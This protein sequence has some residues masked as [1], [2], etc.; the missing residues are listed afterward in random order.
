MGIRYY[1]WVFAQSYKISVAQTIAIT[2]AS[3]YI[4]RHLVN[5]LRDISGIQVRILCR[6]RQRGVDTFGL[7]SNLEIVEGNLYSPESLLNLLKPG[8]TVINLAYLW[9]NGET[10]NL[11]AISNLTSA[12]IDRNVKRL[13]HCSTAAVAGRSPDNLI[14]ENTPCQPIT[15][16]GI[17]KLKIERAIR[18]AAHGN[19]EISILRPTSVFGLDGEPLKKL[20]ADLVAGNR[21]LNYLKSCLFGYRRMNL[22]HVTNVVAAISFLTSYQENVDGEVFIISD[23]DAIANNF[24]EVERTLMRFLDCPDYALPP[25]PLPQWALSLLLR[26][27]GRNNINP[28]CNYSQSKLQNLGFKRSVIFEDGLMEYAS[29]CRVKYRVEHGSEIM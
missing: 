21:L 13:I 26:F 24:A 1:L 17:T 29:W 18:A 7:G 11:A 4:G 28:N 22:V 27:L 15:E 16:Y 3:G 5:Q 10:E 14:T 25:I 12:C 8:C 19:F 9:N 6:S 2:G 23:D 20:A